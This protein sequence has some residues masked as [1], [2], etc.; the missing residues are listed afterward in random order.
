M[1]DRDAFVEARQDRWTTLERLLGR[2]VRSAA[3]VSALSRAYRAVAADLSAAQSEDL[4]EDVVRYLDALAGRA[5]NALYGSRSLGG[6]RPLQLL[7]NDFP[8]EL[9]ANATLF[10]LANL[11][12]Y[13]PFLVGMIAC[14][15]DPT[16]AQNVI[17]VQQLESMDLLYSEPTG[18][19]GTGGDAQMAGFYV[20]NNT[21]IALR[22]FATGAF[23]GLGSLYFMVYNGAYLG[24]VFGYLFAVGRGFNL[25]VFTSGHSAWELTGIVVAG[26]AGLR[27]GWALLVTE[28]RTRGASL[29]AAGPVLARLV[30]GAAALILVA[31]LI[32]GFW[33]AS[34]VPWWVKL[35]FGL[36]QFPVV[37]TWLLLGGRG[38]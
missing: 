15:A 21:G 20:L 23:A 10:V 22:C 13:G 36:L 8:R 9:R 35:P 33:S 18:R 4:P 30:S 32:E 19:G 2:G 6:F 31:A 25:L 26:T 28:G 24:T 5:H 34:P 7:F 11:L 12:F 29:R 14:W 17:P 3:D 38:R 27:L 1:A 16:I 37:F